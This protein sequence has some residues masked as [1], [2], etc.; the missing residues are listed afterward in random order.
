MKHLRKLLIMLCFVFLITG[1]YSTTVDATQCMD[2]NISVNGFKTVKLSWDKKS[3][4]GYKIYRYIG[5]D[6]NGTFKYKLIA[7]VSPY[8]TSYT[9]KK[10]KKNKYY[11]Y[12]VVGY[13]NK[14]T[15]Y[16]KKYIGEAGC[17]TGLSSV[18]LDPDCKLDATPKKIK[19]RFGASVRINN[20]FSII[21]DGIQILKKKNGKYVPYKKISYKEYQKNCVFI[22]KNVKPGKKYSY[23]FRTYKKIN[24]KMMYSSTK[25]SEASTYALNTIPK[26]K[27]QVVNGDSQELIV[28]LKN[29][30]KYGDFKCNKYCDYY[31]DDDVEDYGSEQEIIAYSFDNNTWITDFSTFQVKPGEK[32]YLKI[33]EKTDVTYSLSDIISF[34]IVFKYG[35]NDILVE[36]NFAK[37]TTDSSSYD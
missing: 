24:G 20:H 2:L 18:S 11:L 19:I 26:C 37:K 6:K 10:V 1:A 31:F 4:D 28:S 25:N 3:V 17:Y 9:D 13:T 16:K 15:K 27:I 8:T 30:E 7:T 29:N 5:L 21:P 36:Y 33:K 12:R 32:I 35:D 34:D 23:K 22:D 14:N